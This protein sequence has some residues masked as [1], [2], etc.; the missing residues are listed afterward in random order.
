MSNNYKFPI[1]VLF[2]GSLTINILPNVSTH[3]TGFLLG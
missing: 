3:G 1:V 2:P